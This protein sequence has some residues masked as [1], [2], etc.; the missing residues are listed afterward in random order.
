MRGAERPAKVRWTHPFL[1]PLEPLSDDAARQTFFDIADDF[2]DSKELD[3]VLHLT[4]N[5]PLAVDLI[6]HLVDHEGCAHVL[7]RWENEKTSLL[8]VGHDHRSNLDISIATSLSSPRV[9]SSPGAMD[10]LRVLSILPDGLSD[11]ELVQGSFP[12][13]NI[14]VCKIVLLS[15][16]LAYQDD[17][18]RLKLLVPIR[19]HMQYFH[20]S[21]PS[22]VQAVLSHFRLVLDLFH[23]SQQ[24]TTTINRINS[25]F[26][27]LNQIFMQGFHANNPDVAAAIRCILS[28]SLFSR[29][30]ARGWFNL[31]DYIPAALPQS[32]DHKLESLFIIETFL[33]GS[34]KRID[35]PSLLISSAHPYHDCELKSFS[36][37]VA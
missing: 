14:L 10:L 35:N 3:Q 34:V 4:H 29:A 37:S 21:P 1:P 13:E 22:L 31:M 2:H 16:C 15:T 9:A 6:A 24:M 27:N 30:T 25:N 19:E 7:A 33:T 23:G 5:M 11:I 28:L 18:R 36:I 20:P 26:V 12:I 32:S 8:S 17:Q